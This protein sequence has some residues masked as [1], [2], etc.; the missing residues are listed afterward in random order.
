V[1]T[2]LE[3]AA[4]RLIADMTTEL[5]K[6]KNDDLR[7]LVEDAEARLLPLAADFRKLRNDAGH[8]T[9][10]DPI[11]QADVHCNMLV[12]PMTAKLFA[13]LKKWVCENYK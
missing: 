7:K 8:P 9:S 12:F 1:K 13:S 4:Q 2:T 5:K 11:H 10:L 3:A 6:G